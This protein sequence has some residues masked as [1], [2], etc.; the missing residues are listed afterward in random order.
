MREYASLDVFARFRGL[1]L[2]QVFREAAKNAAGAT[3]RFQY[4]RVSLVDC[5][6]LLYGQLGHRVFDVEFRGL[7][8]PVTGHGPNY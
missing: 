5:L 1:N 6:Q 4:I 8:T 3:D 7:L 2:V